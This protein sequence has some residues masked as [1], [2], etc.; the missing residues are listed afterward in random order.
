MVVTRFLCQVTFICFGCV[1]WKCSSFSLL[2][3]SVPVQQWRDIFHVLPKARY[4]KTRQDSCVYSTCLWP[5]SLREN[6]MT[7]LKLH[8]KS[9]FKEMGFWPQEK[10][11]PFLVFFFQN[12]TLVFFVCV[13]FFSRIVP[14]F[15]VLFVQPMLVFG[16]HWPWE[17]MQ[18]KRWSFFS[19]TFWKS[20]IRFI[21]LCGF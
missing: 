20:F 16:A 13:L 9:Q 8:A 19:W 21:S 3:I 2:R 4:S 5:A 18:R 6:S 15:A 17:S 10:A 7:A 1:V 14:T 11:C 12:T